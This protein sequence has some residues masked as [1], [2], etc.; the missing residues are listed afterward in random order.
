MLHVSVHKGPSPDIHIIY[1][2]KTTSI[3]RVVVIKQER[4]LRFFIIQG[5]SNMTGTICV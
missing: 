5:G 4:D 3:M 1:E 2:F